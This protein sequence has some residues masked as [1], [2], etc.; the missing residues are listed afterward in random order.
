M[1]LV[2]L[3]DHYSRVQGGYVINLDITER[4]VRGLSGRVM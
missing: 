3:P 2:A 1:C 4:H